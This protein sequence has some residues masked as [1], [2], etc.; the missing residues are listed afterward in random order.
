MTFRIQVGLEES[1]DSYDSI[2][3]SSST[4]GNIIRLALL[5]KVIED[6][7]TIDNIIGNLVDEDRTI[8]VEDVKRLHSIFKSLYQSIK[9]SP[10][11]LL[12]SI[13]KDLLEQ[14][15]RE[16]AEYEKVKGKTSKTKEE[17]LAGTIE[18]NLSIIDGIVRLCDRALERKVPLVVKP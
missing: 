12:R 10:D 1:I 6:R 4:M 3:Y 15:Y 9:S 18:I 8:E 7:G 2:S 14:A 11:V 5:Y 17:H 16:Y 13:G